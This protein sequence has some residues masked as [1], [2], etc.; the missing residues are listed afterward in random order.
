M[1]YL[2][3]SVL[4]LM[5][6]AFP[7]PALAKVAYHLLFRPDMN[8]HTISCSVIAEVACHIFIRLSFKGNTTLQSVITLMVMP[9]L[10]PSQH[11]W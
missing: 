10:S 6:M 7:C 2:Y 1:P 4:A 5:A 8:D 3:P 9:F 11:S